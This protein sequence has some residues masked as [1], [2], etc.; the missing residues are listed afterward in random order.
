VA[1]LKTSAAALAA[2]SGT[3]GKEKGDTKSWTRMMKNTSSDKQHDNDSNLPPF[4]E[5]AWVPTLNHTGG[6][7]SHLALPDP[8]HYQLTSDD[9]PSTSHIPWLQLEYGGDRHLATLHVAIQVVLRN[10]EFGHCLVSLNQVYENRKRQEEQ[11]AKDEAAG[12]TPKKITGAR[13]VEPLM[14]RGLP[15]R[16]LDPT[17]GEQEVVTAVFELSLRNKQPSDPTLPVPPTTS[18]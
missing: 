13:F 5:V 11:A 3:A 4:H 9:M 6:V 10:G 8:T 14:Y 2:L 7:T 16:M 18:S 1:V 15:L 12:V 17:T